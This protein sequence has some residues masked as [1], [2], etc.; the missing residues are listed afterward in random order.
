[1]APNTPIFIAQVATSRN[2]S[3][4][5]NDGAKNQCLRDGFNYR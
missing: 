1:M 2:L 3:G 5:Y 4:G